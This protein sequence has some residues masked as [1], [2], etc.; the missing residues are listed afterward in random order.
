MIARYLLLATCNV[1]LMIVSAV[2]SPLIALFA[3]QDGT[4]PAWLFWAFGT[5]DCPVWGD[6]RYLEQDMAW[7]KPY[8]L[9]F[10]R[11]ILTVAWNVRNPA[12]SFSQFTAAVVLRNPWDYKRTGDEYVDIGYNVSDR[13]ARLNLGSLLR[14]VESDGDKYFDYIKAA[15]WGSSNYG[16]MVRFGWNL[17]LDALDRF[18]REKRRCLNVGIRPLINLVHN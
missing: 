2:C 18:D 13:K 1:L 17:E 15:R 10:Q 3:R 8:P 5:R 9:W 14:T 4:Y 16:W 7:V 6:E 11:Y 12:Y